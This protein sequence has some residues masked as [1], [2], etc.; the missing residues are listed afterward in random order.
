MSQLFVSYSSKDRSKI[1]KLV[2]ALEQKH[3]GWKI[4]WDKHI[5]AGAAFDREIGRALAE[6]KAIVVCWSTNSIDRDW[7]LDEALEGKER[8]ILVPIALNKTEFPFGYRR[9]QAINFQRWSGGVGAQCFKQLEDALEAKL[10]SSTGN[11]P[12]RKPSSTPPKR[13]S[14]RKL[15][16]GLDGKTIVFTGTLGQRRADHA[17]KVEMVGA[18]FVNAGVTSNTDYLVVGK[19]PGAKKLADAKK[20]RTKKLSEKQ[21]HRL[22]NRTYRRI[23]EGRQIAFTGRLEQERDKQFKKVKRLKAIPSESISKETTF[24]VVGK[25]PGAKKLADA[26]KYNLHVIEEKLWNEIVAS[27]LPRRTFFIF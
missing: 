1:K 10:G 12:S 15:S 26:K 9:I 14:K 3:P 22:L 17:E 6:S 7:V 8:N 5:P 24:L 21:W 27:L 11:K 25:N 19:N 16:G 23:L 2:E 13:R 18:N 4:W 20:H